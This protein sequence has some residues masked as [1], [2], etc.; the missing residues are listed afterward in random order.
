MLRWPDAEALRSRGRCRG[1]RVSRPRNPGGRRLRPLCRQA[2][3]NRGAPGERVRAGGPDGVQPDRLARRVDGRDRSRVAGHRLAERA[4][5]TRLRPDGS[6]QPVLRLVGVR[7][8]GPGCGGQRARACSASSWTR[9]RGR[10]APQPGSTEATL[11]DPQALADFGVAAARRYS[12]TYVGLPRV[13][14]WEVWNEPNIRIYLEAAVRR[15]A[16]RSRRA[17]TG[18]CSTPTTTR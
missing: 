17:G 4:R 16:S 5:G 9:R 10:C 12:G 18:R 1:A 14:A 13:G 15:A 7:R 11:P 2:V 6:R 3:A 8:A